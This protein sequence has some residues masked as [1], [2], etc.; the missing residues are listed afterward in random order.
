MN[1]LDA[2]LKFL[3]D[4]RDRD[5]IK[6]LKQMKYGYRQYHIYIDIEKEEEESNN[7]SYFKD[8]LVITI[9]NRN[10]CIILEYDYSDDSVLIEDKEMVDK[11]SKI[12]EDILNESLDSRIESIID[13]TIKGS[14]IDLNREFKL[15][16]LF[17]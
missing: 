7:S 8:R 17:E 15:K 3:V 16:K 1:K 2:F 6:I 4:N 11:W 14:N 10:V 5:T 12:I 9:D 13:K